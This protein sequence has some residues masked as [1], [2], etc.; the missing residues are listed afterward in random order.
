MRGDRVYLDQRAT[1]NAETAVAI[2]YQCPTC[3]HHYSFKDE[4]AG[5]RF[6][7]R[8]CGSPILVPTSTATASA[9][10][11]SMPIASVETEVASAS[12]SPATKNTMHSMWEQITPKR[13]PDPVA[14]THFSAAYDPCAEERHWYE[15]HGKTTFEHPTKQTDPELAARRAEQMA[16]I[17]RERR[18]RLFISHSRQQIKRD[19]RGHVYFGIAIAAIALLLLLPLCSA[20]IAICLN[21]AVGYEEAQI[22]RGRVSSDDSGLLTV[23]RGI[24]GALVFGGLALFVLDAFRIL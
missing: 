18:D 20:V 2:Q 21:S 13:L 14:A 4:Y 11:P 7:C 17:R 1:I 24:C 22:K 12:G 6:A 15:M 19:S 3:Q 5:E 23:T 8:E 16:E 10:T 9:P